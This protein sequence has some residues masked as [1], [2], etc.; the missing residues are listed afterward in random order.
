MSANT[1][2]KGVNRRYLN[3]KRDTQFDIR[4]RLIDTLY[5]MAE[6]RSILYT[7]VIVYQVELCKLSY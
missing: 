7:A 5:I 3:S 1:V 4:E 6:K 2:K